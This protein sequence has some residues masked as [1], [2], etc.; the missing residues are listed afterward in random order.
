M[1]QKAVKTMQNCKYAVKT[2]VIGGSDK[3]F[4]NLGIFEGC[5]FLPLK[6]RRHICFLRERLQF[7]HLSYLF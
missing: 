2:L 1:K 4:Y 6:R 7:L 5:S 3:L